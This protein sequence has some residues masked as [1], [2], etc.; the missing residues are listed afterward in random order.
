MWSGH[1]HIHLALVLQ[2]SSGTTVWSLEW[3]GPPNN[4]YRPP[5][6]NIWQLMCHLCVVFSSHLRSSTQLHLTHLTL[7]SWAVF[8]HLAPAAEHQ[9]RS[10]PQYLM[11]APMVISGNCSVFLN[12]T[13][14]RSK[15]CCLCDV[16][17]V[18]VNQGC[19]ASSDQKKTVRCLKHK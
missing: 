17:Q 2:A 5:L 14:Q 9:P 6:T 8:T 10:P 13:F 19:N 18:S 3:L 1:T 12:L 16:N 4:I 11:V 15:Q 7:L